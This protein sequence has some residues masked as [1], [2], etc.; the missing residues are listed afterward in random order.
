MCTQGDIIEVCK[1]LSKFRVNQDGATARASRTGNDWKEVAIVLAHFI[2][3][4]K[5]KGLR[6]LANLE[7]QN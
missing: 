7:A 4:L 1:K 5:L 3:L 6:L 2:N